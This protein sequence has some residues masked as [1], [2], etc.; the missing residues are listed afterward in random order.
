MAGSP[1]LAGPALMATITGALAAPWRSV[2]ISC[3]TK[4]PIL[5]G[6]KVGCGEAELLRLALLPLGLQVKLQ[7]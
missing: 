7:V 5:S 3:A 6:L 2:T 1:D 4:T